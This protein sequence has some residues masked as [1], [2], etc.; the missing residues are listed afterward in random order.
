MDREGTTA[1]TAWKEATEKGAIGKG[2]RHSA[3]RSLHGG[4]QQSIWQMGTS[5]ARNA[6]GTLVL[7]RWQKEQYWATPTG[8]T[9][10]KG[11][12]FLV[13][14][15]TVLERSR[16]SHVLLSRCAHQDR[17]CWNSLSHCKSSPNS[18][19]DQVPNVHPWSLPS[20]TLLS[21][22]SNFTVKFYTAT[23]WMIRVFS[24]KKANTP[25]SLST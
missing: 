20:S 4:N 5:I 22:P 12:T 8:K 1:V 19:S 23:R 6:P 3:P 24:T 17:P 14:T 18:Q 15:F 16:N 10:Q 11:T 9:H 21:R 7:F 13:C 2:S 25:S